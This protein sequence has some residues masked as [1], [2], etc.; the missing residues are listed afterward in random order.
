MV[1]WIAS[2]F[3]WRGF[4]DIGV[5]TDPHYRGQG[6]GKAISSAIIEHYLKNDESRPLL[7]R[8]ETSNLGSGKIAMSLDCQRFATLDYIHFKENNA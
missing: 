3:E 6:V 8:H 5:L 4:V 1:H 2:S 7:W